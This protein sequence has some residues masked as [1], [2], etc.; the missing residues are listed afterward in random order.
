M[1]RLDEKFMKR[2]LTLA[3]RGGRATAPNPLVGCVLVKNDRIIAEGWHRRFG[4]PHAEAQA[5]SRAGARSR[6][7]TAYVTL[8][9]CTAHQGKKTPPCA[10]ALARA[11]VARVFTA[12]KDPHPGTSGRGLTLL[13]RAGVK[14][15]VGLCARESKTLNAAFFSRMTKDRPIVIL[16]TALSLDGK[17]A[18]EG[19]LSKWITGPQARRRGRS[20]R[21]ACD[22]VLVGV[23]TVLADNPR[24]TARGAGRNPLRVILDGRLRTPSNARALDGAAPTIIFSA[25]SGSRPNAEVIKTPLRGR[26]LNLRFVLKELARR[27]VGRLL[28]EGGPTVHA[29]FLAQGLVDEA[30]VFLSPKLLAGSRDPNRCLRLIGPRIKKIGP[31]FLFYGSVAR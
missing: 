13:R 15:H 19:G 4:G 27:G 18:G 26:L 11:G 22:A 16:K 23:G 20:L 30:A 17:A 2:A 3:A 25:L 14:T 24:L 12:I 8:E 10:D 31:D 28:I 7:A 9:P 1:N 21:A 29:S 6:G 5:L